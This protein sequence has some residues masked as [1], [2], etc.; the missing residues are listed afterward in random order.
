VSSRRITIL[1]AILIGLVAI[2]VSVVVGGGWG[3]IVLE[4]AGVGLACFFFWREQG[5]KD[6]SA[7]QE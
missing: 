4:V 6:A 5:E 3:I 2:V 7:E 1:S